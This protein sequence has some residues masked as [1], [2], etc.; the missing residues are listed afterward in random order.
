[1]PA[2]DASRVAWRK[3]SY[4][5]SSGGSCV[6]IAALTD[7][8]GE[9]DVAVRGS[10]DARGPA[11]T[12][13]PASGTIS[14]LLDQVRE[15][16][17]DG[18]GAFGRVP[19]HDQWALENGA[20]FLNAAGV[21]DEKARVPGQGEERPVVGRRDGAQPV[22]CGGEPVPLGRG[23][24]ARMQRE[25]HR[26]PQ[27]AEFVEDR[28]Q[29]FWVVGV[30]RAVDR[31]QD[32]LPGFG[33]EP[34]CDLAGSGVVGQHAEG[35]LDDRVTGQHDL[36]GGDA[37][38]NEVGH[39][40]LGRGAVQVG[41]DADDGPVDLLGHRAIMGAQARLDMHDRRA[42]VVSGLHGGRDRVREDL[43]FRTP[44]LAIQLTRRS[45]RTASSGSTPTGKFS[46]LPTLDIVTDWHSW[47]R[48]MPCLSTTNPARI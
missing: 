9:H 38:G 29:S 10:K 36:F 21:G 46:R 7:V 16:G 1:M 47:A 40:A 28:P 11:L 5:N 22:E 26:Q 14:P 19:D 23:P 42:R 24:G 20:L 8:A 39:G 32:V 30:L 6:E 41:E 48:A 13:S 3:S 17:L 18:F 44:I 33:A 4:S 34:G 25:Q 45:I 31:R 12:S 2:P 15:P 35:C 43:E 27:F 37:L